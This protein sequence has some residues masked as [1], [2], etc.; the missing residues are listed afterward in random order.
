MLL[1]SLRMDK[2]AQWSEQDKMRLLQKMH[3]ATARSRIPSNSLASIFADFSPSIMSRFLRSRIPRP[4]VSDTAKFGLSQCERVARKLRK[5]SSEEKDGKHGQTPPRG[6][7]R[8][9]QGQPSSR[10][11]SSCLTHVTSQILQFFACFGDASAMHAKKSGDSSRHLPSKSK[12]EHPVP[13]P[14]APSKYGPVARTA[15]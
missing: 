7:L 1:A 9:A 2:K 12:T 11:S 13:Q 8:S 15:S 5:A 4:V 3:D 10:G 14:R 6:A